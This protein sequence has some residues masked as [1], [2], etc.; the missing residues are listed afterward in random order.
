MQKLHPFTKLVVCLSVFIEIMSAGPSLCLTSMVILGAAG[1]L[2]KCLG[3]NRGRSRWTGRCSVE[4]CG[5]AFYRRVLRILECL[6]STRET[7][8][9]AQNRM[10]QTIC[11]SSVGLN[12]MTDVFDIMT[13]T[14]HSSLIRIPL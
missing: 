1:L 8:S 10:S 7:L 5:C 4:V 2:Q 13:M 11:E 6:F 3:L 14:S 12:G 9:Q